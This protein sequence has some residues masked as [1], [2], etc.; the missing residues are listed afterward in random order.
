MHAVWPG[1]FVSDDSVAQ[2][3]RDI[4]RALGDDAQQL[5]RTLLR[6]GYLLTA[7]EIHS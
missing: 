7:E 6:R 2:C 5:L 1:I 3:V 4:R